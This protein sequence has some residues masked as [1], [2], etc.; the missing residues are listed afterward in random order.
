MTHTR[1]SNAAVAKTL[2]LVEDAAP[3]LTP[4]P[5]VNTNPKP[6][7]SGGA[8]GVLVE[9]LDALIQKKKELEAAVKAIKSQGK[10]RA[11]ELEAKAKNPQ[12]VVGSLRLATPAD[13]EVF[14]TRGAKCH[15]V[16]C[17]VSCAKCGGTH[18][19]NKQDAKQ[20]KFCTTC[21]KLANR[22]ASKAKRKAKREAAAN[23]PARIQAEIERLQ[24]QMSTLAP[25]A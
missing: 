1:K 12:Y 23:D 24:K 11:W 10:D 22:E 19:V 20:V 14:A 4:E 9:G 15:G 17:L 7:S 8:S 2:T 13:L 25:K 21:S 18:L 16:V 6:K 3:E 5:T